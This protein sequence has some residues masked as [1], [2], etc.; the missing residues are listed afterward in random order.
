M[1]RPAAARTI[2]I[3]SV[4]DHVLLR[5]G[6]A[7]V[8]EVEP[9][10]AIVC[11][12]A[13]GLEA[14]ESFRHHRPD[15]VL[16]DLRMPEMSGLQ[17]ISAIMAEFPDARIVVLTTYDGDA[18]AL[19][20]L[21]AGAC[22]YLLK[23]MLRKDLVETI[24]AAHAGRQC[25]PPQIAAMIAE[26]ATD[27]ILTAQEVNVLREIAAGSSNRQIGAAL[28]ITESTVKSH[29]RSLMAKLGANDRAHAVMIALKRGILE[30]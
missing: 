22:G 8:L 25:I 26:H 9:D 2:R 6:I 3:L 7:K 10:M 24:R 27:A 1:S 15:V 14:L 13:N 11:E 17:A 29:V 23:S 4:D 30:F 5:D 19:A 21:K 18:H 20:A 28:G 16:M 12:A